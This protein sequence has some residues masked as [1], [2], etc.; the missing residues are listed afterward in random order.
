MNVKSPQNE[1]FM[2]EITLSFKI[3]GTRRQLE[4]KVVKERCTKL[5]FKTVYVNYNVKTQGF[6][7]RDA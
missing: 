6:V 7:N 4:P 5:T 3:T 1:I 2:V